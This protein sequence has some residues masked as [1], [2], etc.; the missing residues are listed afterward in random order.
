MLEAIGLSLAAA[1]EH[2]ESIATFERAI[3]EQ[4][5][6]PGR[7][8]PCWCGSERKCKRCCGAVSNDS[9]LQAAA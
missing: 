5:W 3:S 8:E 9:E 1:G 7:N 6:P 2:D 4:R